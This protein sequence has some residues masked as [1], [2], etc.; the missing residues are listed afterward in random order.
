MCILPFCCL[1]PS[2]LGLKTDAHGSAHG[3]MAS[4]EVLIGLHLG[5]VALIEAS[6]VWT[7]ISLTKLHKCLASSFQMH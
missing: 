2:L 6:C 1:S 5:G 7:D 3:G 4:P